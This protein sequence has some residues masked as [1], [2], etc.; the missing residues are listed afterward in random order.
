MG[1]GTTA[2]YVALRAFATVHGPG[3][4]IL[5]DIICS[6]VLDAVLLAGFRPIFAEVTTD[7][8]ASTPETLQGCIQPDTRI[9]IAAHVFGCVMPPIKLGL[10]VIEDAV[11]GLGGFAEGKSV[12]M[13]GDISILS[14]HPTKMIPGFGGAVLTDDPTLWRAIQAVSLEMA[15][16]PYQQ[17]VY[18]AYR[19]QL[20]AFRRSLIVPFDD[21]ETNR[22]T[23]LAG[24]HDLAAHVE[25]RNT[26]AR[27]LR[28]ALAAHPEIGLN[29]PVIRP[30]DAIWRYPLTTPTRAAAAWILRRLQLARLPG[31]RPYPSLSAIYAPDDAK[32]SQDLASR[33]VN[34]W[35]DAETTYA[36]L[37]AMIDHILQMPGYNPR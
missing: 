15:V 4:A 16:E 8:F 30:G 11:Q 12:G 31:A 3:S 22:R 25:S 7:R 20:D 17:G 2:L 24:W 18:D 6:T 1:R 5:P 10:S 36:H 13:L 23:I 9:I 32:H 21:S 28:D 35:V 29:L 33:L 14:F 34:L 19:R 27:Y 26:K 37:D